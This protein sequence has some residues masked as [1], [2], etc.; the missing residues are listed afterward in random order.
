ML[1]I[2][3]KIYLVKDCEGKEKRKAYRHQKMLERCQEGRVRRKLFIMSVVVFKLRH[4]EFFYSV[5][6]STTPLCLSDIRDNGKYISKSYH[7]QRICSRG[8]P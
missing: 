4:Y 7:S 6:L 1:P 2:C 3:S 8:H 5:V